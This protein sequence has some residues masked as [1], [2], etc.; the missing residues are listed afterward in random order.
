MKTFI[1][2]RA[3]IVG[4]GLGIISGISGWVFGM[5]TAPIIIIVIIVGLTFAF[6]DMSKS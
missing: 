1:T 3:Y 4:V 6:E 2:F 5:T